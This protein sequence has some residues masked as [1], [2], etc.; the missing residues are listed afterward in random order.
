MEMTMID[1][2]Q[3]TNSFQT[4]Q[5]TFKEQSSLGKE[6]FLRLLVT[7]LQNQDP[8]QPLQDREFIAQ[9]TQFSTLEQMTNLNDM[10]TVFVESQYVG[11]LSTMIGKKVMWTDYVEE[12]DANGENTKKTVPKEGIVTAVSVKDGKPTLVLQDGTK[13]E[14][15]RVET[16]A[17]PSK[18]PEKLQPQ[19]EGGQ[20]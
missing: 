10:F 11:G 8:T 3:Y 6:D 16:V 1:T 7:Q 4:K 20:G 13:L 18:E 14:V 19:N 2:T 12:T 5:K 15:N 17:E 9:M